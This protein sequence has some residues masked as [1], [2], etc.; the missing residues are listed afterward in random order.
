MPKVSKDVQYH[1][2]DNDKFGFRRFGHMSTYC[3]LSKTDKLEV[4]RMFRRMPLLEKIWRVPNSG[5]NM[6]R[7]IILVYDKKSPFKVEF[8][9]LE[10]RKKA[11][12][13]FCGFRQKRD[14]E[15]DGVY[16]LVTELTDEKVVDGLCDF[17]KFQNDLVWSQI[18]AK[19]ELFWGNQRQI[20]LGVSGGNKDTDRMTA[21]LNAVKLSKS[22][23]ALAKEIKE[24][25]VQFTG[26]DPDA[27]V[28]IMMRKPLRPETIA[29]YEITGEYDA[30]WMDDKRKDDEEE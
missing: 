16:E 3:I 7:Y 8:H 17:L 10:D 28:A 20:L 12:A 30:G 26:N 22:N 15:P 13:A 1:P 2:P 9:R 21:S 18:V 14:G 4:N 19:E 5:T 27:E 29:D 11:V 6:V 23:D 25:Y 24:L